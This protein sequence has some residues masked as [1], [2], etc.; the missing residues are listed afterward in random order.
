MPN[1]RA[2][3]CLKYVAKEDVRFF[4]RLFKTISVPFYLKVIPSVEISDG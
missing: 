4:L 2:K 1:L 3:R